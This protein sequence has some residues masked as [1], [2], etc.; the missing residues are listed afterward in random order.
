MRS[1][2]PRVAT[3]GWRE[4][5]RL[6]LWDAV[7]PLSRTRACKHVLCT[8]VEPRRRARPAPTA[9]CTSR[10]CG[11]SRRSSG[12]PRA[13]CATRAD[14]CALCDGGVARRRQRQGAARG[15]HQPPRSCS[16]SCQTHNPLPG[17]PRRP[18]R[19]GRALPRSPGRRRHPGAR[20]PLP[21]RGRGRAGVLRHHGE[22][23]RP[24]GRP[25]LG[26]RASRGCSTSRS[27]SP[28][29]S[30]RWPT[31]RRCSTRAPRRSRSTRRRSR[32]PS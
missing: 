8:D 1:G 5:S 24:L 29:A 18:G 20:G 23:R 30:A 4:Q 15:A 25:L 21:R 22:P 3:H 7:A 32:T 6:Q 27:A 9:A 13:A 31:P 14:L 11:A 28:A 17:R 16:H 12:R 2:E 10:R 26:R 19:Q